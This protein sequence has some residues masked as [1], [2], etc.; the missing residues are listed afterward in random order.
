MNSSD[1]ILSDQ[2]EKLFKIENEQD[3]IQF[4]INSSFSFNNIGNK[5]S[6]NST[7]LLLTSQ[8]EINIRNISNE[9]ICFR[10]Q[11]TRQTNYK[12][13][14]S[15]SILT[16]KKILNI[17]I[18]FYI[19]QKEK[20]NPSEHKFKL[21]GFIISEKEKNKDPN[22]LFMNY[23]SK[24]KKVKGTIIKKNAS[25][26]NEINLMNDYI[27]NEFGN[28]NKYGED[29]RV[30]EFEDLRIEY[31]KLKGI[32]ENLKIEYLT[33]KK[34]LDLELK[35]KNDKNARCIENKYDDEIN[36]NNN[37]YIKNFYMICFIASIALG[38][39]LMK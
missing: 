16:P 22:N 39:F 27:N 7:N 3:T 23:I 32:N 5:S 9:F 34:R 18:Y 20:I 12:I 37:F 11:S 35:E 17:K 2:T 24:G 26:I 36:N 14:P 33:I 15:Y 6:L 31:C 10:I 25:F 8:T 4:K 1:L 21:E 30:D 19:D 28:L 29:K 38:F 13:T